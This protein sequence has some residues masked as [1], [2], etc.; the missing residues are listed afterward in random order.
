[1]FRIILVLLAWVLHSQPK[2]FL[3]LYVTSVILDGVDGWLARRL[4]QTSR[5]GAWLDVVVD[6]LGRGMLWN[7]LYDWGWLVSSLEWCVFVCNHNLRGANWK[8]SFN[9]TPVW[10]RAVM[11][12]G[13]HVLPVWLFGIQREIFSQV[14]C[15]P[16]WLE[17]VGVVVLTAGRLL[18]FAV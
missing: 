14:L 17:M 5:F 13:L 4:H 16:Y 1:Y 7:M 9:E 15:V 11:A 8:N 3:A 6:N 10:V 2:S 18:A 12:K